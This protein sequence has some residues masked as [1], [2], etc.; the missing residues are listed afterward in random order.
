MIFFDALDR[1]I[2]PVVQGLS[3]RSRRHAAIAANVANAD[4]PEYRAI[5]VTFGSHLDK[6]RLGLRTT[7][8][9]HRS[10]NSGGGV[11]GRDQVVFSGGLTRRDG[12]DVDIDREMSKLARNQIEYQFLARRLSSKFGKLREA[13]TGK[14][15][16]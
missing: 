12:N 2:A 6:A 15:N 1:S 3:H 9:G 5:D 7:H 14:A 13:I 16:G 11:S 8:P 10:S 4:T